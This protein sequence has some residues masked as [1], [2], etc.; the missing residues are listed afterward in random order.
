MR[1]WIWASLFVGATLTAG[2]QEKKDSTLR[3]ATTK[4]CDCLGKKK[5]SASSMNELQLLATEC[6]TTSAM[7]EFMA[8]AEER[9][10]DLTD[11]DAGRKL[12]TEVAMDLMKMKCPAFMDIARQAAEG[13]ISGSV[14]SGTPPNSTLRGEDTRIVVEQQTSGTVMR[15]EGSDLITIVVKD[16]K[17]TEHSFRWLYRFPDADSFTG[18]K[19]QK[20]KG[21][22]VIIKWTEEE[23][24]QPKTGTFVKMKVIQGID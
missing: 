2:A 24:Y 19:M 7:S 3:A 21:S 13:K 4:I 16:L 22:K 20:L 9:N 10:L 11:Q 12:G 23:L 18:A 8:L 5:G 14:G 15:I 17:G 6:I 1:K